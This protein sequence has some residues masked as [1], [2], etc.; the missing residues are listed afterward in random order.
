MAGLFLA[1]MLL[2]PARSFFELDPP[3]PILW[4]AA[5]GITTIVW[6][7]ARLFVPAERPVGPSRGPS[8][9]ERPAASREG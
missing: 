7:F 4:L 8:H 6:S 1:A 5:F 2:P 9:R 3:T